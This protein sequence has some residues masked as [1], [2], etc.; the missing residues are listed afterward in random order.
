MYIYLY[1]HLYVTP[2][3]PVTHIYILHF[4]CVTYALIFLLM[5]IYLY[6]HLCATPLSPVTHIYILHFFCV[7]YA[8]IF[9]LM[10]IYLYVHL[11]ATPLSPVLHMYTSILCVYTNLCYICTHI[12]THVYIYIHMYTSEALLRT[13]FMQYICTFHA[14]VDVQFVF[15]PTNF[16]FTYTLTFLR[17][18]TYMHIHKYKSQALICSSFMKSI[19]IYSIFVCTRICVL[20]LHSCSYI[21]IHIYIYICIHLKR[22]YATASFH[23]YVYVHFLCVNAFLCYKYTHVLPY[24]CI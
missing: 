16:W 6:I 15:V 2:L 5:Y 14:Y 3:S 12:L 21:C 8:L 23:T 19:C 17:I 4:F 24:V 18:Y 7:T 1:V 11:C 10:Y 13:S 9:L 20:Q 22:Y